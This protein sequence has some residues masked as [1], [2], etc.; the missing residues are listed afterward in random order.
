[1]FTK[2]LVANRGEIAVRIL[3]TCRRLGIA[4]VAVHS[5]ADADALHVR[6][7]DEAVRIGPPPAA[8]SYLD[9]DAIID[10]ALTTGVEAV[11]P[12]YGFLAENPRFAEACADAGLVFVGPDPDTIRLMGDKAEAKRHLAAAGVPVIPGPDHALTGSVEIAEAA[13]EVG[14]PVLLKA[15]AG[16][17]GTGMRRV[18]GRDDLDAAVEAVR[19]EAAA[20]FG[21]DRLLVERLVAAPRHVEV[22]IFGDRAGGVV[23]LF[24][25]ECS[26][27]RRHQKVIEETPSPALD[28]ALREEMCASAVTAARSVDYVG[29]GT[30]EM[31]LSD[32]TG[33][34][35]FLE[36]N[37]RLQVEHPVTELVTGLDLVEWQLRV[38]AGAPLPLDQE[39]ITSHGHAIEAR[40]YA[41]DP[42]AGYLPQTGEVLALSLPGAPWARVDVG[43]EPGSTVSRHYDPMLA[44]IAVHGDDRVRSIERL[45]EAL[46]ATAVL[47][48]VTNLDHLAAIA[49]VPALA[50][51]RLTTSFIDDHLPD[52]E[53]PP[54]SPRE[55]ALTAVLALD[56]DASRSTGGPWAALGPW[57][58]SAVGGTRLRLRDRRG[59]EHDLTVVRETARSAMLVGL[60]DRRHVVTTP[61]HGDDGTI[62]VEIDGETV[63]GLSA[64]TRRPDGTVEALWLRC[65][66]TTHRLTVV[67]ATQRVDARVLVAGAALASPMP[68]TVA[69]VNV[70]EGESVAAGDTL[71]VVEA[72]KME[73]GIV[74][75]TAGTVSAVHAAVGDTVEA[76]EP[77]VEIEPDDV[78]AGV[79]PDG[80]DGPDDDAGDDERRVGP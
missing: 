57:R 4:T 7:A 28:D 22:Q 72:M 37:T 6:R 66:G 31:L 46:A 51:G 24:E 34:H 56:P 26:I 76:D 10:A 3:A 55:L 30:V 61:R 75:P 20:A 42:A 13:D 32:E 15:V 43:I 47:G 9:V 5:D 74:A 17:G 50:E 2:V 40:L 64:V 58:A 1:M 41:E 65:G 23:H 54:P 38:A 77:L 70:H 12:G 33:E 52:W 49:R 79:E 19:R 73:H 14:F 21:D 68:G 16:G 25:R 45:R 67:P 48:V 69:A 60:H 71:I 27:Q 62:V 29:A 36:M 80:G 8:G 59:D 53:P 78:T 63:R 11:H 44:K 39:Q 18:E 35:Y